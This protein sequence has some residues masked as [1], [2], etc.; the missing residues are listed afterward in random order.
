LNLFG[1]RSVE[2]RKQAASEL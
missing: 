2:K 1:F